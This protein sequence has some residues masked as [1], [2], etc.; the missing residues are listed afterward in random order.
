MLTN[1]LHNEFIA[2]PVP[3]DLEPVRVLAASP[4]VLDLLVWLSFHPATRPIRPDLTVPEMW[5]FPAAD[6]PNT[7][8]PSESQISEDTKDE[9]HETSGAMEAVATGL[10]VRC[11]KIL[12]KTK[13]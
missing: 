2:H 11:G 6:W 8:A 1:E 10:D 9:L 13:S 5:P 3:N 7:A 12:W 4:A